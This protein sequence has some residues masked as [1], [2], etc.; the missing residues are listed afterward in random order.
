VD[1]SSFCQSFFSR[2]S[3]SIPLW[4][5]GGSLII[6]GA[7]TARS[8]VK[9]KWCN[10]SH[11]ATAFVTVMVMPLT[12][13]IAYRL[14]AGI[15]TWK[16]LQ[17]TFYLLSLA[18]IKKPVFDDPDTDI[19]TTEMETKV[20]EVTNNIDNELELSE[21]NRDKPNIEAQEEGG[22]EMNA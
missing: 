12:Y 21:D 2:I 6:A 22:V 3:A 7:L 8:L 20:G 10:V 5:T 9:V 17:S 18:G 15:V 13:L 1:L 19:P 4:V 11:A 16:I 14:I